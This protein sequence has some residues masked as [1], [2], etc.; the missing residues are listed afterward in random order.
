MAKASHSGEWPQ[1]RIAVLAAASVRYFRQ[2]GIHVKEKHAMRN[3][4]IILFA[5]SVI[6]TTSTAHANNSHGQGYRW[7][8]V[9]GTGIHYFTTAMIHSQEATT[10]GFIQRSTDI[11]ELDGDIKGRVLYHPM[12]VFDF[13]AGTLVNTGHQVFSGTVLGSAPAMIYDDEF[14]FDVNLATGDTIGKIYLMDPVAGPKVQCELD[15]VGTGY[16]PEGD[17]TVAYTG[18]CKLKQ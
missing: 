9:S 5:M 6:A 3:I 7:L 8:P 18:R 17:A 12:S 10:T 2:F 11:V 15:V 13:V 16:T 1:M 14:R 4:M